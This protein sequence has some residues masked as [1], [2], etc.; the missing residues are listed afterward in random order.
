MKVTVADCLVLDAFNG[1]K[2]LAGKL[3]LSNDVKAI[4]VLDAC[5]VEDVYLHK[6]DETEILLT[7]FLGVKDNVEKQCDIVKAVAKRGCAA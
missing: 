3:N 6:G 7:G 5:D 4:S 2:V 1:A